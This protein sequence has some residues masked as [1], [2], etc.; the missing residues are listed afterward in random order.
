MIFIFLP[1]REKAHDDEEFSR[2]NSKPCHESRIRP[3]KS[4]PDV[5]TSFFS[6][7]FIS[8]VAPNLCWTCS[9]DFLS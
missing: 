1:C 2:E 6:K 8:L 7:E 5:T 4:N 9:L 3:I